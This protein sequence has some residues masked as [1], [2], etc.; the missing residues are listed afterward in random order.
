M[1]GTIDPNLDMVKSMIC[2]AE[3]TNA[4]IVCCGFQMDYANKSIRMEQKVDTKAVLTV[5]LRL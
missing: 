5:V 4:D 2:K 3:A 1:D